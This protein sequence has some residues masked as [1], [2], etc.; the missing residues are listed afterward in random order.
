MPQLP[1]SME[2]AIYALLA[3]FAL[4]VI[5]CPI[6]IP[7]LTRLHFGQNIR[8]DG[9][10]THIKKAGT[11][12]MGG[13]VIVVSFALPMLFFYKA[14]H[15]AVAIMFVTLGYAAIGFA[16]DFIKITRHRSLGLRA[17]QKILAQL[18]VACAFVWYL[19]TAGGVGT[20]IIVPFV[21]KEVDL[22]WIYYTFVVFT[23]IAVVNGV[24]LTD[25][26]DGLASGV[27]ALVATFFLFA[28]YLTASGT[29]PALG[30]AVGALLGFLLFNS[31][32]AK[33]FMGDTGSLALGGFIGSVALLLKMPLLIIIVGL[34]YV[35]ESLSVL[36][37]VGWFK[38]SHGKRLFKMAPLHHHFEMS[39]W[40]ETKVVA[41]FYI[42][43]AIMCL[44]GYL[45]VN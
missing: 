21:E 20:G 40:S 15:Q 34:V 25:G 16:D 33:V 11:P 3:A 38:L 27:T 18:V 13:V 45:S 14:D 36:L 19:A 31:Y 43:T 29:L 24:N 7:Y 5:L 42:T 32:P 12:T 10:Q 39:G 30:A 1:V 44:V 35:A 2:S 6:A 26:L 41:L 23:M 22:G 37:Q 8:D 4:C 28:A 17:Y 9:P